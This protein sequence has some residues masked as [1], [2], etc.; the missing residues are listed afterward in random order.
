MTLRIEEGSDG[1]NR[2]LRLSGRIDGDHLAELQTQIGGNRLGVV[3]DLE[4]ITVV[5]Q[6]AVRYL[7]RWEIEGLRLLHCP[8]YVREWI[9]ML[10][11]V[12]A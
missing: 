11:P 9:R 10:G 2:L 1:R 3:L 6:E 4:E 12:E 5:D 8:P 7:R